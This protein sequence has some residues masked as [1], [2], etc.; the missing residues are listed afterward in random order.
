ME[1][2]LELLTAF[3][4]DHNHY[5]LSC[6]VMFCAALF[7]STAD[8]PFYPSLTLHLCMHPHPP[9]LLTRAPINAFIIIESFFLTHSLYPLFS[10]SFFSRILPT[11]FSH[12]F[13]TTFSTSSHFLSAIL[14]H[15]LFLLFPTQMA[16]EQQKI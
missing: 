4:R 3:C 2:E 11:S 5:Y 16:G 1:Y 13:A 9:Y 6:A 8:S 14:F 7:S 12:N 15:K 10:N